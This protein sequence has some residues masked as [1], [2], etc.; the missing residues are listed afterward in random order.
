MYVL[1]YIYFVYSLQIC[2]VYSMCTRVREKPLSSFL[3]LNL[4]VSFC[5]CWSESCIYP[6]LH[7]NDLD[8]VSHSHLPTPSLF[9]SQIE[10]THMYIGNS[11]KPKILLTSQENCEY[12]GSYVY[13]YGIYF[14]YVC[15]YNTFTARI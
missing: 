1:T 14:V 13:I 9:S 5:S 4:T 7:I 10:Y 12:T 8:L 3:L 6:I 2:I 11:L 15:V